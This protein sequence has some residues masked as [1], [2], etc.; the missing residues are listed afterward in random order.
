MQQQAEPL[1]QCAEEQAAAAPHLHEAAGGMILPV[2]RLEEDTAALS[3]ESR[4]LTAQGSVPLSLEETA[5]AR[6]LQEKL[7]VSFE[8]EERTITLR[9]C[10]VSVEAEGDGFAVTL[11]GQRKAGTPPVSEAQCR[12][13]E[14]LCTQTLARCWENG[15]DLLHLGAVRT[16]KQGSGEEMTAKNAYP[17]VRVS[18][19]MLEF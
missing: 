1:L 2:V 18:V 7:P 10:V 5:M 6:L 9:R 15:L 4:L 13:L 14:A 8:L 12:Q 3:K 16:L 17:A 19:E 11:T